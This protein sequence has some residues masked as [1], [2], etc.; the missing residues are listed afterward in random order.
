M[1]VAGKG[2]SCVSGEAPVPTSTLD[3]VVSHIPAAVPAKLLWAILE[4]KQ[5]AWEVLKAALAGP[6]QVT[7]RGDS[8]TGG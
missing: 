5:N 7:A 6:Q 2:W 3:W 1:C 4:H 8:W